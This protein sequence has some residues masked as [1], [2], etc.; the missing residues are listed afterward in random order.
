MEHKYA[1]YVLEGRA[2]R[3]RW[4]PDEFLTIT[5][6]LFRRY[7]TEKKFVLSKNNIRLPILRD[8]FFLLLTTSP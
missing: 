4:T 2:E 8:V 6:L 7:S 5:I 3:T 1:Y